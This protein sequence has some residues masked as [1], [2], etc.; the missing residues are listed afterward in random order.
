M[1]RKSTVFSMMVIGV[2]MLSLLKTPLTMVNV[3]G[4]AAL[5]GH[6]QD[7]ISNL[8]YLGRECIPFFFKGY[9]TG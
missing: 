9:Q 4:N 1:I 2:M 8:P 6:S 3:T 7:R 5:P